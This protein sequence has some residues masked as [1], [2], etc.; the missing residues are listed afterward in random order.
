MQLVLFPLQMR[1]AKWAPD[2]H[3][4][5]LSLSHPAALITQNTTVVESLP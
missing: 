3:S 1:G 4:V 2:S 5:E